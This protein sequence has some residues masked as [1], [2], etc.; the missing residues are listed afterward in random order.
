MADASFRPGRSSLSSS[1]GAAAPCV[2]TFLVQKRLSLRN[3]LVLSP[4]EEFA[5]TRG[6]HGRPQREGYGTTH[7]TDLD[8]EPAAPKETP[9]A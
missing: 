3:R 6:E 9:T 7:V 1:V 8:A 4:E 5:M 2:G